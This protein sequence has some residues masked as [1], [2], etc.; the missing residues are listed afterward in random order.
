MK[1]SGDITPS[2]VGVAVMLRS[3]RCQ[4]L[5]ESQCVQSEVTSPQQ[6]SRNTCAR[7]YMQADCYL[8]DVWEAA[9]CDCTKAERR[10]ICSRDAACNMKHVCRATH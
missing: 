10:H 1:H 8:A 3:C 5:Y 6:C 2:D 9:L 7:P 4:L